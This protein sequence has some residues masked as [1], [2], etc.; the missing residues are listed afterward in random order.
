MPGR[1]LDELAGDLVQAIGSGPPATLRSE[2]IGLLPDVSSLIVQLELAQQPYRVIVSTPNIVD[3]SHDSN[4]WQ[5]QLT[6]AETGAIWRPVALVKLPD[7]GRNGARLP[8][9]YER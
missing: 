3:L 5:L 7:D 4:Q 9:L 2:F 6:Q 1:S 8:T